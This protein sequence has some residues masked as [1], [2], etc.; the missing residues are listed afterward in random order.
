M[1]AQFSDFTIDWLAQTT[2]KVRDNCATKVDS[3]KTAAGHEHWSRQVQLIDKQIADF[4]LERHAHII[5]RP[6]APQR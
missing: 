3:A 5:L 2:F 4:G 6:R 1:D